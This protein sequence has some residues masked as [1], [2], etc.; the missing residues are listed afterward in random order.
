MNMH[1]R[2]REGGRGCIW[3]YTAMHSTNLSLWLQM[4]I[5]KMQMTDFSCSV[6]STYW[7]FGG[8]KIHFLRFL[9][10]FDMEKTILIK[11]S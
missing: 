10:I 7:N 2:E 6:Q 8:G 4:L 5:F 1:K 3:W 9:L 11:T